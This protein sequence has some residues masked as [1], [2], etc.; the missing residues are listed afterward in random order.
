MMSLLERRA[1]L[2]PKGADLPLPSVFVRPQHS[3]LESP[4]QR[5]H[6]VAEVSPE[7]SHRDD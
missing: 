3:A 5:T 7:E 4:A 6:W 1:L 2:S